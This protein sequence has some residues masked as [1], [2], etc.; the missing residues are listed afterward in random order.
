MLFGGD[1]PKLCKLSCIGQSG[2]AGLQRTLRCCLTASHIIDPLRSM[3][4]D[5]FVRSTVASTIIL[6]LFG[7]HLSCLVLPSVSC[8]RPMPGSLMKK[9]HFELLQ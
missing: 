4:I 6:N 1:I 2:C 8:T 3:G 5:T 9:L 7:N